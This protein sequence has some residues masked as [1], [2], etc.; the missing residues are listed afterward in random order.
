MKA[1]LYPLITALAL[2]ASAVLLVLPPPV[3]A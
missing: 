1:R 3:A 2:L